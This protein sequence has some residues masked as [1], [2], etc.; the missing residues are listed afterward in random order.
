MTVAGSSPGTLTSEYQ[1]AVELACVP[2]IECA[3]RSLQPMFEAPGRPAPAV[4]GARRKPQPGLHDHRVG[5][6][7]LQ[8]ADGQAGQSTS[9]HRP[10][11][12]DLHTAVRHR[13]RV[14][15]TT[16][17]GQLVGRRSMAWNWGCET[18]LRRH[19]CLKYGW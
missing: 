16:S 17:D 1:S 3:D 6:A 14:S 19:R 12:R 8:P 10:K 2:F 11:Q 15:L 9:T 13:P 18:E 5:S 7:R 4:R